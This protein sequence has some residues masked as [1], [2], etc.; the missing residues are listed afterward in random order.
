MENTK[1]KCSSKQHKDIEA[2]N[3]CLE[4][5]IYLCNKCVKIHS[6]FFDNHHLFNLDKNIKEI[7]TGFCKE[8]THVNLELKYYCKI[9][10]QLCCVACLCKI[11][12]KGNGQHKD[13]DVCIIENIK[14]EKKKKIK[15]NIKCLEDLSKN[16]DKSINDLKKLFEKINKD[17]E[18]LKSE[19]QNIFTKIRNTINEREDELLLEVDNQFN[20]FFSNENI[21]K[22]SEKLPNKVKKSLENGKLIDKDWNDNNKLNRLI[23]DC[24]NIENNIK[25]IYDINESIE[26]C[27]SNKNIKIV[28]NPDGIKDIIERIK[29]YGNIYSNQIKYKFKKCPI[30][31]KENRK[32]EISGENENILTKTGTDS[33]W[34]GT[35]CENELEKDKEYIWKI[36]ILYSKYKQ[37]MIGV[38]PTDFDINS[39]KY[40]NCGYYFYCYNSY[41]FSGPPYS[42]NSKM[43]NLSKVKDEIIVVMNM[44]KR[45]LKFIINNEDKGDQ[46]SDIPIDKPLSPAVFLYDKND[47]IK[48]LRN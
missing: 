9:H 39:S 7:F 17:K 45:T 4:C 11:K 10:N 43:T 21:I 23:N 28:F 41:L 26:K 32:Y 29:T 24:I 8:E 2:I 3:Y 37:I 13:C 19:I 44:K 33:N 12:G 20:I 6:D 22:E 5:K 35:I 40:N 18:T 30:N 46:Y 1:K 38:A 14:D 31:V 34:M 42:F 16:L 27:N 25:D 48:I 47:S 36:K 15:K